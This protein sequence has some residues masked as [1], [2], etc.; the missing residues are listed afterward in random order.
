MELDGDYL[1]IQV[2]DIIHKYLENKLNGNVRVCHGS[3]L[4]WINAAG[5]KDGIDQYAVV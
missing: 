4:L 2:W 5:R 1:V 3:V